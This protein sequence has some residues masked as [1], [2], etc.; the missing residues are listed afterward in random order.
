MKMKTRI[1]M[2]MR[3]TNKVVLTKE[4]HVYYCVLGVRFDRNPST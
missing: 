3:M 4:L 1:K 2:K